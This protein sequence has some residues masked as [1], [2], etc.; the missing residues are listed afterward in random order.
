MIKC[1]CSK[2]ESK[3]PVG[4]W[5]EPRNTI[6][7]TDKNGNDVSMYVDANTIVQIMNELREL[8]LGMTNNK[9]C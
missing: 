6:W 8:L 7:M 1:A 4:F 3:C 5:V 9:E 2:G